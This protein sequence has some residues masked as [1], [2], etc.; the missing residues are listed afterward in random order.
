MKKNVIIAGE[1]GYFIPK[2]EFENGVFLNEES[3]KKFREKLIENDKLIV[4][5]QSDL[6]KAQEVEE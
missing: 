4:S 5:L 3:L 6:N 2:E 1:M